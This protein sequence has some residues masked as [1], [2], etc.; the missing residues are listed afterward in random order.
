MMAEQ[1]DIKP[2]NIYTQNSFH[3]G[4][5]SLYPVWAPAILGLSLHAA[6]SNSN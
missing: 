3:K 5:I 1:Q 6:K 4:E 2:W